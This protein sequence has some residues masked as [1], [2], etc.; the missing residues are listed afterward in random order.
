MHVDTL[1]ERIR[2]RKLKAFEPSLIQQ[3]Q[4]LTN[5]ELKVL[6]HY[7][8]KSLEDIQAA[9]AGDDFFIEA[10]LQ[11]D[12]EQ[13]KIVL[14]LYKKL[15]T[16]KHDDAATGRFSGGQRKRKQK[17]PEQIVKKMLFLEKDVDTGVS[18]LKPTELVGAAKLW[19]YNAKT[20][21]LGAYVAQS[22]AG[23]SAKGT[24]ILNYDPKQSTTKTLR[25]PTIQVNEFIS[26]SPSEMQKFWD[27]IRAV[28]QE[29]GPRMSRDTLILRAIDTA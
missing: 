21:K 8:H 28:P 27:G 13:M 2:T 15:R 12:R 5:P 22:D 25:K 14:Q 19:V 29:I 11:Y 3:L 9:L 6:N 10:Y 20:R 16:L 23:L 7:F 26:K 1:L 24:T 4:K 17:P 18:S